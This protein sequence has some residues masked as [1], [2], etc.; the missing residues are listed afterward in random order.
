MRDNTS[1][2]DIRS[3]KKIHQR[4]I[5]SANNKDKDEDKGRGRGMRTMRD[6]DD[7]D[8]DEEY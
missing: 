1:D 5:H 2:N 4:E 3:H 7:D 8:E 6:N